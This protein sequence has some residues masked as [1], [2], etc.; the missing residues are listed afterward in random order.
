MLSKAPSA[1]LNL[2][3]GYFLR[4]L[5]WFYDIICFANQYCF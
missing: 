2:N 5:E 1:E 3:Q 4:K